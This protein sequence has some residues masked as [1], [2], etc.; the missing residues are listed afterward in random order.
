MVHALLYDV[1]SAS[2]Q[3]M[4]RQGLLVELSGHIAAGREHS[5]WGQ[6]CDHI[7]PITDTNGVG[8]YV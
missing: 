4:Q 8:K 7:I 2:L 6:W 1:D 5:D 3:H